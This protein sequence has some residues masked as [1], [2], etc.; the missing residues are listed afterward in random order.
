MLNVFLALSCC[1]S[2]DP[3]RFI[4][5]SYSVAEKFSSFEKFFFL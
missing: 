4:I 1:V 2:L 5:A 3:H